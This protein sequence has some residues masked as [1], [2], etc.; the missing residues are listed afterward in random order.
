MKSAC[1]QKFS[2]AR[3]KTQTM[4]KS[5]WSSDAQQ[6][7]FK[8]IGFVRE[9]FLGGGRNLLTSTKCPLISSGTRQWKMPFNRYGAMLLAKIGLISIAFTTLAN[10]KG[11][12]GQGTGLREHVIRRIYIRVGRS[13]IDI[14]TS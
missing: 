14:N 7:P 4:T 13:I 10:L 3:R 6:S 11:S 12:Q 2:Q 1:F 8:R 5:A 9:N